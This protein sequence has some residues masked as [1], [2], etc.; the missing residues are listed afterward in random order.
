M[1]PCKARMN[2]PEIRLRF[3]V[4]ARWSFSPWERADRYASPWLTP[5]PALG[6][7]H[8]PAK[9]G[10]GLFLACHSTCYEGTLTLFR[11]NTLFFRSPQLLWKFINS[12]HHA[13]ITAI[14]R[15]QLDIGVRNEQDEYVWNKALGLVAKKFTGLREISVCVYQQ[16]RYDDF[17]KIHPDYT[18]PATAGGRFLNN[19][20]KLRRRSIKEVSILIADG[21]A[22]DR[23]RQAST[24]ARRQGE[25]RWTPAQKQEWAT[26]VKAVIL[27][28]N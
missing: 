26:H 11:T 17:W 3:V 8:P 19:I 6:N 27:G 28:S 23:S 15:I 14:R 4:A 21:L 24:R 1:Q 25:S 22:R 13:P 12:T 2:Y 20:Y 16:S 18:N 9:Y 7:G 10:S 5:L